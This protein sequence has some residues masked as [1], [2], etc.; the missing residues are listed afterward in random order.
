M[1]VRN[2]SFSSTDYSSE[3]DERHSM[4]DNEKECTS[5]SKILQPSQFSEGRDVCMSCGKYHH[6]FVFHYSWRKL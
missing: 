3:D 2:L 1:A 4:E 5:C 6:V